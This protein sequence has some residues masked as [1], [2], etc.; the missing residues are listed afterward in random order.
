MMEWAPWGGWRGWQG[1]L[2][3]SRC[4]E[5][6]GTTSQFGEFGKETKTTNSGEGPRAGWGP[7]RST[8]SVGTWWWLWRMGVGVE[9]CGEV[10]SAGRGAV[11]AAS[12]HT[13]VRDRQ[14]CRC[15][16]GAWRC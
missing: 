7:T 10:S 3:L 15:R 16:G 5:I 14:V 8:G 11:G 2:P 12:A 9:D 13:R 1:L 6:R 4:L